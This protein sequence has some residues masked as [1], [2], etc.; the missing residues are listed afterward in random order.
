MSEN[1]KKAVMSIET[2]VYIAQS[3]HR[4]IPFQTIQKLSFKK[5]GNAQVKPDMI[6]FWGQRKEY[7]KRAFFLLKDNRRFDYAWSWKPKYSQKAA[8]E[9]QSRQK[10]SLA[11][12]HI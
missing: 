12:H 3:G 5:I 6:W 11:V 10:N 9:I 1:V 7:Q 2:A 4:T 8:F